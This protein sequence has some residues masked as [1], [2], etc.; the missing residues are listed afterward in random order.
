MP[1]TL[2]DPLSETLHGL[3]TR[4]AVQERNKE[5]ARA[6]V[7]AGNRGEPCPLTDPFAAAGPR[8][9]CDSV[10]ADGDRVVL[11]VTAE[12]DGASWCLL[13]ELRYD[14]QGRVVEY[15]GARVPLDAR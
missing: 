14:G 10:L 8:L 2:A 1:L 7:E 5:L 15:H 13:A 4:H 11:R 3:L 12:A 6:L 9:A